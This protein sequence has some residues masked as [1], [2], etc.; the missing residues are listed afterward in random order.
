MVF[1][2]IDLANTELT[3]KNKELLQH[4]NVNVAGVILFTRN[5]ESLEQLQKLVAN[6]LDAKYSF[7]NRI[8]SG[9]VTHYIRALK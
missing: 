5:Y 8:A 2:I 7:I 3:Q 6:V 4:P 1:L 9:R